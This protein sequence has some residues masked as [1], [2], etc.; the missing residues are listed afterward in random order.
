ML[1]TSRVKFL[2]SF[3]NKQ[4]H[5]ALKRRMDEENHTITLKDFEYKVIPKIFYK[6]N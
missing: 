6:Q 4:C 3:Y 1:Q 2:E 5:G